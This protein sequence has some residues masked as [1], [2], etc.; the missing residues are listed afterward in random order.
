MM[1]SEERSGTL[2]EMALPD[3]SI[4]KEALHEVPRKTLSG[5]FANSRR[6]APLQRALRLIQQIDTSL[7]ITALRTGA[8]AGLGV[9]LGQLHARPFIHDNGS[10][11][12]DAERR[13][14]RRRH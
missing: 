6:A 7:R 4:N 1:N 10:T 2:M 14:C 8:K 5:R 12:T 3:K 13:G 11:G 9:E